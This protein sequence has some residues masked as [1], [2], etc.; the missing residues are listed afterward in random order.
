VAGVPC[1]ALVTLGS[2]EV[3]SNMAFRGA[4]EALA[5][6]APQLPEVQ[7]EVIPQADHFYTAGRDQLLM[8]MQEW[9]LSLFRSTPGK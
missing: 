8:R 2:V 6:A 4:P 5:Q 3:E 9:L 7:L 1:P